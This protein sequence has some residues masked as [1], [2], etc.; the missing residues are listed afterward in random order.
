[1]PEE[2]KKECGRKCK[3]CQLECGKEEKEKKV[4]SREDNGFSRKMNLND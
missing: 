1:M 2:E 3:N 4:D